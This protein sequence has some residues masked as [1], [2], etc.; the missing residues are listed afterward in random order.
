MQCPTARDTRRQDGVLHV[1]PFDVQAVPLT[2]GKACHAVKSAVEERN[3]NLSRDGKW[4]AYEAETTGRPAN[5]RFTCGH[6]Q[7]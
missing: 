7:T 6:T 4:M 2:P 5:C 1:F 3:A